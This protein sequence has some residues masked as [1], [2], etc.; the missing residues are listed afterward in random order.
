MPIKAPLQA[1]FSTFTSR[2]S[3]KEAKRGLRAKSRLTKGLLGLL[4]AKTHEKTGKIARKV[5]KTPLES[6]NVKQM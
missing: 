3:G 1:E 6:G 4:N 5:W 2:G